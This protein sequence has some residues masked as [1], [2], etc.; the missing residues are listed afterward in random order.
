MLV[1][2]MKF[3][4]ICAL[5]K[6]SSL[7]DTN[8]KEI[9]FVYLRICDFKAFFYFIETFY[10]RLCFDYLLH[11]FSLEIFLIPYYILSLF[12]IGLDV[13]IFGIRSF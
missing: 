1:T 10:G 3:L 6:C 5:Q 8:I 7:C 13:P 11:A 9:L 4:R 2:I 12:S